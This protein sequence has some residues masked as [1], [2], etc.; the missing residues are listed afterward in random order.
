VRTLL[1]DKQ[2]GANWK[3]TWHQDLTIA[4]KERRDVD[5]FGPWSIK[6]GIPHVQPPAELLARMIT[7]RVHL[8]DCFAENGA[9]RILPGTHQSGRLS[10]ADISDTRAR[11]DEIVC[12]VPRG[13]VLVMR[14]LLLHASSAAVSPRHRR[15]LHLEFAAEDLPE[16]LAWAEVNPCN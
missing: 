3:V 10:P 12:E 13:G 14:P 6:D 1:F 8:D 5:G 7:L 2:P 11:V 15:V 9:L 4:V 16:G